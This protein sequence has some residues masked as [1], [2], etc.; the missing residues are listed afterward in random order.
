M[1]TLKAQG[2]K[3][4]K[5]HL[6]SYFQLYY[7]AIVMYI[8]FADYYCNAI[9]LPGITDEAT[10]EQFVRQAAVELYQQHQG[11]LPALFKGGCPTLKQWIRI[12]ERQVFHPEFDGDA[13]YVS[14]RGLGAVNQF[15]EPV[16]RMVAT[17]LMSKSPEGYRTTWGLVT[18][19]PQSDIDFGWVTYC[20]ELQ[21]LVPSVR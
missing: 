15:H 14:V 17:Y 11:E 6:N 3:G 13:V 7:G 20:P 10:L 19:D 2:L 4:L 9:C 16:A 18:D 8:P 1:G 12:V 21:S 5:A